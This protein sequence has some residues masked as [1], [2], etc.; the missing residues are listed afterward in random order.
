VLKKKGS[1]HK[2]RANFSKVLPGLPQRCGGGRGGGETPFELES[3]EDDEKDEDEGEIIF[4]HL[5]TTKLTRRGEVVCTRLRRSRYVGSPKESNDAV[6]SHRTILMSE[7]IDVG[8]HQ[9]LTHKM[10]STLQL[11]PPLEWGTQDLQEHDR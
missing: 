11:I 9:I 6:P 10:L 4:P 5:P 1:A 7:G 8:A 3:S 2:N